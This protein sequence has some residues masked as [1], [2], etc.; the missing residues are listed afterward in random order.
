[1]SKLIEQISKNMAAIIPIMAMI[2]YV[3]TSSVNKYQGLILTKVSNVAT[4]ARTFVNFPSFINAIMIPN[5]I[6]MAFATYINMV[7]QAIF[8]F[9]LLFRLSNC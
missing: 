1:M 4:Q 8:I 3:S 6:R 7:I 2:L 9:P 5:T